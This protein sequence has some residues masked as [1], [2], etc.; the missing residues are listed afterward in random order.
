MNDNQIITIYHQMLSKHEDH[1]EIYL[2][3]NEREVVIDAMIE[4]GRVYGKYFA[5]P[6][7]EAA[8]KQWLKRIKK[9]LTEIK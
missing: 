5:Q 7:I 3:Q 1:N 4:C 2:H 9:A 8:K 6:H